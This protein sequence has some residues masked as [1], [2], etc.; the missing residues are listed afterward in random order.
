MTKTLRLDEFEQMQTQ[1][2]V[3]VQ[4]YCRENWLN[5][6]KQ[7]VRFCLRDVGKGWFNME[8]KNWKVYLKSKLRKLM[9]L[10]R[11][12]MEVGRVSVCF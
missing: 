8:E 6:L 1:T 4:T 3:Q 11:F 2:C 9:E 5:S 12:M 10:I 7:S